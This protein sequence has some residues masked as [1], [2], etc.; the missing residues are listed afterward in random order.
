MTARLGSHGHGHRVGHRSGHEQADRRARLR[1]R[2]MGRGGGGQPGAVPTWPPW[3]PA[4]ARPTGTAP[5]SP[6]W[7]PGAHQVCAFAINVGPY[8]DTN[9]LLGCLDVN[10]PGDP[11]G[12]LDG[13]AAVPAG[14]RATGWAVDPDTRPRSTSTSTSTVRL[15]RQPP[16]RVARPDVAAALQLGRLRPR[17]RRRTSRP[18]AAPT[19]SAPTASTSGPPASANTELG[20]RTVIVDGSP[21]GTLEAVGAAPGG[22]RAAGLG[23]RPRHQRRQRAGEG[24]RWRARHRCRRARVGSMSPPPSRAG[25]PRTGSPD[26]LPAAPGTHSCVP[27]ASP[28]RVRP[29]PPSASAAGSVNVPGGD[30][31]GNFDGVEPQRELGPDRRV[32]DRPGHR[33]RPIQVHVY[34]N[35]ALRGRRTTPTRPPRRGRGVPGVRRP[36]TGSISPSASR[37][38]PPQVCVFAINVVGGNDQP[39]ARLPPRCDRRGRR[40]VP[41]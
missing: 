9:P 1:R 2:G 39:T 5:W 19:A 18:P 3:C 12:S 6:T 10:V 13:A 16:A 8:G 30:P 29:A 15:G 22:A 31:V 20:C 35:G 25:G 21:L 36:P 34:V 26:S 41:C 37:P 40:T 24:R 11:F 4:T 33:P 28:T 17:L 23:L 14:V 38:G 7:R 27:R 32:D